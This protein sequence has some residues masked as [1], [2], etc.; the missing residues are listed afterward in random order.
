MTKR[1]FVISFTSLIMILA[2]NLY[3]FYLNSALLLEMEAKQEMMKATE[4]QLMEDTIRFL[5]RNRS[6]SRVL[7]PGARRVVPNQPRGSLNV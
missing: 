7:P 2:L 1:F 3:V 4:T 5:E 6:R